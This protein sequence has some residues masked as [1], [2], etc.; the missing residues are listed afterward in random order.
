MPALTLARGVLGC[1]AQP[2]R[3]G[4]RVAEGRL[5]SPLLMSAGMQL[6]PS[7][8]QKWG[9]TL[10]WWSIGKWNVWWCGSAYLQALQVFTEKVVR[11][12]NNFLE[13]WLISQAC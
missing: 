3:A 8:N 7:S 12:W 6:L 9:F 11:P 4:R 1:T 13:R 10:G 2:G 5:Q